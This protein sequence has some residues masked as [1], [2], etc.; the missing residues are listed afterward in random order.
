LQIQIGSAKVPK[1]A[2]AE[3]GDTLELVERP[4]GGLS[5]VLVDG[6]RSGRSAKVISNIVV[7]K[8]ISLL[9]EGVRDGAAARAAH[10]YLRTHRVGQ[11]SAELQIISFDLVTSSVVISRNSQCPS[12]VYRDGQLEVFDAVSEAIGIQANTKPVIVEIPFTPGLYVATYTDG[13]RL[14]A[15]EASLFDPVQVVEQGARERMP[16]QALADLLLDRALEAE[17][18]RPRDDISVVVCALLADEAADGVRRLSASL[19]LPS[20]LSGGYA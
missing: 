14:A 16:A 1:Y 13:L 19:P 12:L 20:T 5:V 7:R 11:V 10:D 18:R 6:Q 3:S 8:A 2:S 15:Q 9:G 17:R 4:H